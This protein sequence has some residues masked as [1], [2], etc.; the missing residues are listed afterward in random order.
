MRQRGELFYRP[1]EHRQTLERLEIFRIGGHDRQAVDQG[2]CRDLPVDE[3][4]RLFELFESNALVS[5]PFCGS[6][7]V[8]EC[9][10]RG[11]HDLVEKVGQ[12]ALSFPPRQP[13]HAETQLVPGDA[14]HWRDC[15]EN[16]RNLRKCHMAY[17]V[18]PYGG[19]DSLC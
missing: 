16:L 12:L 4:R 5:V 18:Q 13:R 11:Q 8:G 14:R 15:R 19:V 6:H 2:H 7:V 17:I 10:D 9:W 3:R 1:V